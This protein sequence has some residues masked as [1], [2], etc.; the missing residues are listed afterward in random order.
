MY[1]FGISA[2]DEAF[3]LLAR[4]KEVFKSDEVSV[5]TKENLYREFMQLYLDLK[6]NEPR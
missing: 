3:D 2:A 4:A 5:E 6:G 1:Y